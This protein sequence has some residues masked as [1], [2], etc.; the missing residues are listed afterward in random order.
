MR[1]SF[2][3]VALFMVAAIGCEPDDAPST[4]DAAVDAPSTTD[5]AVDATP[6]AADAAETPDAVAD[7]ACD[8]S[9][10][11]DCFGGIT[12]S[13]GTAVRSH[14]GPY[15]CC[16]PRACSEA[17]GRGI[18]EAERLA[19]PTGNCDARRTA[20]NGSNLVAIARRNLGRFDLSLLCAGGGRRA[21]DECATDDDCAPQ[22]EGAPGRLRCDRDARA[23][24][25]APRP[26]TAPGEACV[27]D[28]DCAD[29]DR[30]D[31]GDGGATRVCVRSA[32]TDGGVTDGGVT[33]ASAD[34]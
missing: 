6:D 17:F 1:L 14:F 2:V 3:R 10:H 18:C 30:C 21:G 32:S 11:V 20:C 22:V 23:C 9:A 7:V 4:T 16:S 24:A 5:A 19:C 28:D 25:A 27:W 15:M 13:M 12:C 29:G 26:S 8:P 34:R 33:D 31:C